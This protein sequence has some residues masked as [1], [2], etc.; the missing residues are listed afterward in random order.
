M[1]VP[2]DYGQGYSATAPSESQTFLRRNTYASNGTVTPILFCHSYTATAATAAF[3]NST[4]STAVPPILRHLARCG[5]PVLVPDL[6]GDTWG[7]PTGITRV[8]EAKTYMQ[9]T[10]GAKTGQVVVAGYSEGGLLAMAYARANPS[11]VKALVLF[12]PACDLLDA[13]TNNR[14]GAAASINAAFTGGAYSDSRDGPTASPVKFAAQLAG[15][16]TLIYHATDDTLAIPTATA[17]VIGLIGSSVTE[18][19][20]TGGHGD[21][22]LST[23]DP[24]GVSSWLNA[25]GA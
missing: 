5:W 20:G 11:L 18:R 1:Y 13:V 6:A 24:L 3:V 4:I 17:T 2:T 19:T 15:I 23:I 9:S 16:P 21:G 25:Q 12:N 7:N 14:D 22:F 8:G 10:L